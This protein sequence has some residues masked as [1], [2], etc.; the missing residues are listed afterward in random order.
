M[1]IRSAVLVYS[2][3][4]YVW[5]ECEEDGVLSWMM[6]NCW[7]MWDTV[8]RSLYNHLSLWQKAQPSSHNTLDITSSLTYHSKPRLNKSPEPLFPYT[9]HICKC[10]LNMTVQMQWLPQRCVY[11]YRPSQMLINISKHT[12]YDHRCVHC[13][14]VRHRI[15]SRPN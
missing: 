11:H 7:R 15:K 3:C 9:T 12:C 5:D 10:K 14:N 6:C 8:R 1:H 4:V 2:R 13:S